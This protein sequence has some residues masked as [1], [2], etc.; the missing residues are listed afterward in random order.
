[1]VGMF[2]VNNISKGDNGE[3]MTVLKYQSADLTKEN[4]LLMSSVDMLTAQ[5][6]VSQMP[7]LLFHLPNV[8]R[9][10]SVCFKDHGKTKEGMDRRMGHTPEC[11]RPE[12]EIRPESLF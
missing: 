11:N 8:L 2:D 1:M 3:K 7:G 12:A 5:Y 6:K 4:L 9:K 10:G